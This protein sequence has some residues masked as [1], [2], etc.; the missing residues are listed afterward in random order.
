MCEKCKVIKRKGVQSDLRKSK[1][2]TKDKV[3]SKIRNITQIVE[4]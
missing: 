3:N 1:T 2:Q 4:T